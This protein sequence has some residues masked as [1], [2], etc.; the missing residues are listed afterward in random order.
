M[1]VFSPSPVF[2]NVYSLIKNFLKLFKNF[3]AAR[4]TFSLLQIQD[5]Y[6]EKLKK[7][8]LL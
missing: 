7:E 2:V 6:L 1:T 8:R 4:F 5:G 3:A